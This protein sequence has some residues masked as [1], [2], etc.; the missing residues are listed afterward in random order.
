LSSSDSTPPG[1]PPLRVP[2]EGCL[3]DLRAHC[4]RPS[5]HSNWGSARAI[6]PASAS[7]ICAPV[8]RWSQHCRTSARSLR[9]D[10]QERCRAHPTARAF[11]LDRLRP[12][13][14]LRKRLH[15]AAGQPS[16]VKKWAL[17]APRRRQRITGQMAQFDAKRTE[18]VGDA[19]ENALPGHRTVAR[20]GGVVGTAITASRRPLTLDPRRRS[21]LHYTCP[22]EINLKARDRGAGGEGDELPR[23]PPVQARR[24]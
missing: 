22:K 10:R 11:T 13:A 17:V 12:A 9:W 5:S 24:T 6:R 1:N 4:D 16:S 7:D 21:R 14:P 15:E 23:L 8:L 20:D 18:F 19:R 3:N 2:D